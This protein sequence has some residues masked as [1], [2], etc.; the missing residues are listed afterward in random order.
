[1]HFN[2][3]AILAPSFLSVQPIQG[4]FSG[5]STPLVQLPRADTVPPAYFA[6]SSIGLARFFE[7]LESLFRRLLAAP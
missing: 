5:K 6:D 4:A 2:I 7:N 1:V 3:H